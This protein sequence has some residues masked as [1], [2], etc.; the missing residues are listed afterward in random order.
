MTLMIRELC[1][2]AR[3]WLYLS[4]YFDR[5]R[6]DYI[7]SLYAVSTHGAWT[8]WL[9]LC[10]RAT[11]AQATDTFAR[12]TKL[13]ALREAYR[14]RVSEKPRLSRIVDELFASQFVQI[15][16]LAKRHEVTYPTAQRDVEQL[17]QLKI[18]IEV[19]HVYPKT[20]AAYEI[21]KIVFAEPDG[22]EP[23]IDQ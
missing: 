6:D 4:P 14:R 13:L 18:V 10:L 22:R 15:G 7:D 12:C 23:S 11:I 1:D 8:K 3:P 20:Y 9:E 16:T 2:H 17:E 19:P 21:F 5:F